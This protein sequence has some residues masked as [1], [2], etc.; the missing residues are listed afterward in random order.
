MI[1]LVIFFISS[2][3]GFA[4]IIVLRQ[5]STS[6]ILMKRYS[7]ILYFTEYYIVLQILIIMLN[8]IKLKNYSLKV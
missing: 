2:S 8:K 3:E 5:Y 7:M 6:P 1:E 4:V